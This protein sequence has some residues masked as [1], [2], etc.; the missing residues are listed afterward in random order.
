MLLKK[1]ELPQ[2]VDERG[3][4]NVLE[5]Q[6]YCNWLP[7]RLYYLTKVKQPRGAHCVKG[8]KKVYIC[9]AGSLKTRFF[10]GQDWVE[11]EMK[12]PSEAILMEGDFWREFFDFSDD[13]VL[14][15][16]SNMTYDPETYIFDLDEY[17]K[18]CNSSN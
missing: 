14:A 9:L 6:N 8:E 12:G 7:K 4:L 17:R 18:Y 2:F 3:S 10:D 13:C 11:M 5:F 1:I 15:A 16:A